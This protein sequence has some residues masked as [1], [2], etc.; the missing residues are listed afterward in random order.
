MTIISE[1]RVSDSPAVETIT[2]GLTL[3]SGRVIR[4][5][6][7]TWHIVISKS[8]GCSRVFFVGPWTSS[9]YCTYPSDAE[10]LWIQFKIGVYL[11][12]IS[13]KQMV[14]QETIMYEGSGRTFQ[15]NGVR[16][17]LPSFENAES[18]VQRLI[19]QNNLTVDPVVSAVM[20]NQKIDAAA[21]TVRDRF[22]NITGQ[23]QI[24]IRQ[25]QRAQQAAAWLRDG[26]SI[27][28]V[29][30][31]LQYSDQSHLTRSLRRFIGFTPTQLSKSV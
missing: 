27:L 15:L 2:Q 23:T 1:R 19:R 21:R 8:S 29:T 22:V 12:L 17:Q 25:L 14:N 16:Y 20:D 31:A 24:H 13:P 30:F 3:S 18:F 7:C 28:D 4:P 11:P 10:I 6:I 5:A 9:G 26:M